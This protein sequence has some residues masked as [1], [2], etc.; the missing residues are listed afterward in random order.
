MLCAG[1]YA[2]VSTHDQQTLP[3]QIRASTS[4][5]KPRKV[6]RRSWLTYRAHRNPKQLWNQEQLAGGHEPPNYEG[7]PFPGPD[8]AC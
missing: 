5:P 1:L 4:T 2:R 3:L 6:L 8:E 7:S